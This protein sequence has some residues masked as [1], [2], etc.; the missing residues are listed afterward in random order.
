M[1]KEMM[2]WKGTSTRKTFWLAQLILLGVSILGA[3]VGVATQPDLPYGQTTI[4]ELV[5][6]L[7]IIYPTITIFKRRLN[8][9]GWSGWWM[10]VP[11]L[12]WVVAGFFKSKEA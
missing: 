11:V 5:V 1:I 12:N 9:A 8:D 4:A 3:V 7:A 6:Y 10:L 2:T